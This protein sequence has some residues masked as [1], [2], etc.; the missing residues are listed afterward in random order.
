MLSNVCWFWR[1]A[2]PTCALFGGRA[3]RD[4]SRRGSHKWPR[5]NGTACV[6]LALWSI[7]PTPAKCQTSEE[8][9]EHS[10][11]AGQQ[12]L[13]QR[14]FARAAED[15][16]NVLAL[17]P[18]LVEAEVNLGLAEQGLLDYD[19]AVRH[20]SK[21]LQKKPD[22]L[23]PNVIVGM[24]YLKLGSPEKALPFLQHALKL[25]PANR[26]AREAL[27]S[28]YLAQN[29]FRNA[30]EQFRQIALHDSDKSE[31]W[32]KLGH[33]YLDL[34]ARLAYRGAHL[35]RDSAWGHRFLGDLLFQRERWEEAVKEYQKALASDAQ[36]PGLHTAIGYAYLHA[37]KFDQSEAEFRRELEVNPKSELAWFGLA[38]LQLARS[39]PAAALESLQKV[40]EISP[41]FLS[42]QR[43]F[44]SFE[45]NQT[46]VSAFLASLQN[47]PESAAKHFLL[48]GL[49]ATTND[50]A[51]ADSHW[52]SFESNFHAWQQTSLGTHDQEDAC[53]AHRYSVCIESLRA[54][55]SLTDSE[56]LTLGKAYFTVQQFEPAAG[57]LPQVHGTANQN[58]EASYW[59][60]RTY[61]AQGA[62]AYARLEESFP[63]GW[64]THQ[65]R[66]ESN[67]VRGSVPEAVKEFQAALPLRP[68]EPELYEA[69]GEV[70]LEN[71]EY[72][73]AQSELEKAVALDGLRTHTLYLLGRVFVEKK[74]NE[75][76]IPYLEQAVRLQPDLSEANSLLGT[77]YLR[78]GQYAKAIATLEKAAASD[79]YGNVHYQMAVAYR[80]LGQ[81]ERAKKEMELSQD[82]RQNY[83]ARD[84]ALIM[85]SP[86]PEPDSQ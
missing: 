81:P 14:Q 34:A 59:L 2:G 83:L 7:T 63:D 46:A 50:G 54:R 42:V 43:E 73:A 31:A 22:L 86:Q 23:G 65:L 18:T 8:A 85:G 20:L 39:Q 37:Q 45:L 33:Q 6:L 26:D 62:E 61:Q 66:G 44:P 12:A 70:Y 13:Q 76:A 64:R 52:K 16:K 32:F 79:H 4:D 56:R 68:N 69:L 28:S 11:R 82:L 78:L 84:Q 51:Q 10:F 19:S 40:W 30:A 77:A 71:V 15:F 36:Q 41:E 5:H 74:D 75:K 48:A 38:N 35:Y 24:D 9:I 55:K 25:D 1:A 29:D 21:A 49:F 17:D 58:A 60:E 3:R 27:A 67:A 47:E 72:E 57:V 80:K 53:K